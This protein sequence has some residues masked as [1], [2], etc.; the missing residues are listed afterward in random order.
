VCG[1]TSGIYLVVLNRLVT[2]TL[3]FVY[4]AIQ[5]LVFEQAVKVSQFFSA[6]FVI[7][8]FLYF[9]IFLLLVSCVFST[10]VCSLFP[11]AAPIAVNARDA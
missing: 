11:C 1:E 3:R 2:L 7:S 9:F 5:I 6:F 8:F 10:G 4:L